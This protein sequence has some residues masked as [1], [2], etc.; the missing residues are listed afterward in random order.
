M[1]ATGQANSSEVEFPAIVRVI[2]QLAVAVY[3]RHG[4]CG[5]HGDGH[6][7]VRLTGRGNRSADAAHGACAQGETL[8]PQF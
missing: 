4:L 1:T 7:G 2:S 8:P 5:W 3:F 6:D